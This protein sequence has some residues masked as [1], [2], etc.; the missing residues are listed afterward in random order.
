M[1]LTHEC[2]IYGAILMHENKTKLNIHKQ[3]QMGYCPRNR[4]LVNYCV[5]I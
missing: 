1:L 4:L 2:I 5:D 3:G